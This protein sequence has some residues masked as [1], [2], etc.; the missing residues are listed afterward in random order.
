MDR[1]AWWATVCWRVGGWSQKVRHDWAQ[2]GTMIK[3][4]LGGRGRDAE[5]VRMHRYKLWLVIYSQWELISFVWVG[6]FLAAQQGMQ[7]LTSLTRDQTHAPCSGS[8]DSWPL[9]HQARHQT[10]CLYTFF[11]RLQVVITFLQKVAIKV[12]PILSILFYSFIFWGRDI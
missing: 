8:S 11:F 2:Q 3:R 10:A 7:D 4:C 9:D 12:N 6:V 5:L 1:G